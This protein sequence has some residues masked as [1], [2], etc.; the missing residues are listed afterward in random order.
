MWDKVVSGFGETGVEKD[1]WKL[2][3]DRRVYSG[4]RET[5]VAEGIWKVQRK[6]GV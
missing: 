3:R 1:I 4:I 6:R 5:R 2:Q